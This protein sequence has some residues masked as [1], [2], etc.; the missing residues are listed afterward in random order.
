V[1]ATLTPNWSAVGGV[2]VWNVESASASTLSVVLE[3]GDLDY[4]NIPVQLAGV[5]Q[6]LLWVP[7]E[8]RWLVL[9]GV[10][11]LGFLRRE[12]ETYERPWPSYRPDFDDGTVWP[13]DDDWRPLLEWM[14]DRATE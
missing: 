14:L 9:R 4:D 2:A 12:P 3:A 8:W 10:Q 1:G 5:K 6:W 7:G 11:S 13:A